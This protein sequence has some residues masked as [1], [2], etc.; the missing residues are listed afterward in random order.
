MKNSK[1]TYLGLKALKEISE[2]NKGKPKLTD[3]AILAWIRDGR[4]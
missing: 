2:I 3:K 4:R 1:A